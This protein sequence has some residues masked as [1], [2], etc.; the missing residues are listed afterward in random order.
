[1]ETRRDPLGLGGRE[2]ETHTKRDRHSDTQEKQGCGRGFPAGSL[3]PGLPEPTSLSP[4]PRLTLISSMASGGWPPDSSKS[5]VKSEGMLPYWD[6]VGGGRGTSC[7]LSVS[8]SSG[9]P[10]SVR[11]CCVPGMAAAAQ[12]RARTALGSAGP[13]LPGTPGRATQPDSGAKGILNFRLQYLRQG[14]PGPNP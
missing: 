9:V 11:A 3:I 4:L 14:S 2:R 1:M 10:P 6:G 7:L 13:R 12:E 8:R 5:G